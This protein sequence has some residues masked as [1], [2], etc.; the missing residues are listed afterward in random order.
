MNKLNLPSQQ[1]EF[2]NELEERYFPFRFRAFDESTLTVCLEKDSGQ[3]I[4]VYYIKDINGKYIE[5]DILISTEPLPFLKA[6]RF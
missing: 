5:R 1:Q 3:F 6:N 2:V 4:N